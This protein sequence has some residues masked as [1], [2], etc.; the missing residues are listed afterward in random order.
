MKHKKKGGDGVRAVKNKKLAR[1]TLKATVD[2]D[3]HMVVF[4]FNIGYP[5]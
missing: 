3:D 4:R 2:T 5:I 1:S